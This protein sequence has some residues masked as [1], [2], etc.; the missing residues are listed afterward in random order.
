MAGRPKKEIAVTGKPEGPRAKFVPGKGLQLP[1]M[2]GMTFL[3]VNPQTNERNGWGIWQP[4][5]RDS[6]YGERI[7]AVLDDYAGGTFESLTA[8]DSNY[9]YRGS[10]CMLAMASI[11]SRER[12]IQRGQDA[13]DERMSSVMS[14]DTKIR[15]TQIRTFSDK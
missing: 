9:F 10:D 13:A 12:C 14:V 3:W 2:D 5:P 1:D 7:K 4:V 6:E 11:E 8:G 15:H